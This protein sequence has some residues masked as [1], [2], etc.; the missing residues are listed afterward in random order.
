MGTY[1]GA[2][3][4]AGERWEIDVD[5]DRVR[6]RRAGEPSGP[7]PL[8]PAATADRY[9]LALHDL[10]QAEARG[11]DLAAAVAREAAGG[12]DVEA[13]REAAGGKAKASRPQK[14]F[15]RYEAA[16]GEVRRL[17]EG[18]RETEREARELARWERELAA[19]REAE[20]R[21][22]R[23]DAALEAVRCRARRAEARSALARF[24]EA[25]ERLTGDE[26]RTLEEHR[27]RLAEARDDR[28]RLAAER[29]ALRRRLAEARLPDE[30][31]PDGLLET[32]GERRERAA[33][34]ERE[35]DSTERDLAG[36][37]NRREDARS[38]IG[39]GATDETLRGLAPGG[40]REVLE[41]SR[42]AD[43]LAASRVALAG[44]DEWTSRDGLGIPEEEIDR[45]L[46]AAGTEARLLQD[47]LREGAAGWR[48]RGPALAAAVVLA[49]LAVWG[50]LQVAPWLWTL[51]GVA[52]ALVAWCWLDVSRETGRRRFLEAEH[53]RLARAERMRFEPDAGRPAPRR[54][55][56]GDRPPARRAGAG[57]PPGRPAGAPGADRASRRGAGGGADGDGG[58]PR[59]RAGFGAG[60]SH[61]SRPPRESGPGPR[62]LAGGGRRG[63]GEGAVAGGVPRPAR[64]RA[65]RH[66]GSPRGSP[67]RGRRAERPRP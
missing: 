28:E 10:L 16:S 67:G 5:R 60:R 3:D 24:S 39:E 61:P 1:A 41:L 23:I 11:D 55:G 38:E 12:Y 32:L 66:P 45:R 62:P 44:L 6:H 65:G 34:R 13:A 51:A 4:L 25:S 58:A 21:V 63:A 46:S 7:P 18:Q 40:W 30:G 52:A 53:G 8:P 59:P 49:A 47:W 37:R 20:A 15:D 31:L 57:E 35:I 50:G 14:L 56:G 27:R 64:P 22:A 2:F 33:G 29:D 17:E 42:R 43:E 48:A 36:A 54:A 19:A 9:S 26:E